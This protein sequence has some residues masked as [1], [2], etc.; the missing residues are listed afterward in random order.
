MVTTPREDPITTSTQGCFFLHRLF[1]AVCSSINRPLHYVIRDGYTT[2]API[3][4]VEIFCFTNKS[5]L[6]LDFAIRRRV[7]RQPTTQ[8]GLGFIAARHG[9]VWNEAVSRRKEHI[10]WMLMSAG[11]GRWS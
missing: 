8:T 5:A 6:L 2:Q 3:A 4:N 7:G 10:Q 9:R 1:C 11:A